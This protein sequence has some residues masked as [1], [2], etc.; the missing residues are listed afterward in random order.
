M[1]QEIKISR[2]NYDDYN[3]EN[4]SFKAEPGITEKLV[5]QISKD[6]IFAR[7]KRHY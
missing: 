3:P 6:K 1:K 7:Q 4:L 2:K 5:R